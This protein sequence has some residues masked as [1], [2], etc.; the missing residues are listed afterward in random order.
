[1]DFVS[2]LVTRTASASPE[3]ATS[4]NHETVDHPMKG[5]PVIEVTGCRCPGAGIG[6]LPAAGREAYEVVHCLGSL[7][8]EKQ[9]SDITVIGM[10]S[11]RLLCHVEAP[12]CHDHHRDDRLDLVRQPSCQ[13]KQDGDT[14]GNAPSG[15]VGF[16]IT[17]ETCLRVPA[18]RR[19][20]ESKL[21]QPPR[22]SSIR[23]LIVLDRWFTPQLIE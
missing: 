1:M 8:T 9:Q 7:I 18:A 15:S 4:L 19:P 2:E 17:E 21:R 12:F 13:T 16:L 11:R 14:V 10:Q 3:W 20:P 22:I 23:P 6:V 5:E